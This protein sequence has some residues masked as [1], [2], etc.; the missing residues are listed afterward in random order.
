[1]KKVAMM[2]LVAALGST[3][4]AQAEE[5]LLQYGTAGS[6][7]ALAPNYEGAG[8]TGMDLIMGSGLTANTFSTFNALGWDV[9]STSYEDAVAA[10]DFW[11]FGFKADQAVSLTHFDIRLDRS[12]TGPDDFEIRAAIEGGAETTVLAYDFSDTTAGI[13]FLGIDLTGLDLL[14]GE[15]IMFTLAAFNSETENGTFDLETITYPGGND[16]IAIYGDVAPVPVP[17]AAW[18]FAS[19]LAG[20]GA[21][22]RKKKA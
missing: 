22:K 1:M 2:G 12:G 4:V 19:G 9:A 5:L 10:N 11:T 18:L 3:G 6:V 13:S 14:A 7:T 8:V 20:L 21:M 17:A 15:T 16:G